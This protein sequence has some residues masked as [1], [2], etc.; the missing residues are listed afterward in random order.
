MNGGRD[1]GQPSHRHNTKGTSR[2]HKRE[3]TLEHIQWACQPR[4]PSSVTQRSA[5]G[6]E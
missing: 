2:E 5:N 6:F 3:L 4:L 1:V